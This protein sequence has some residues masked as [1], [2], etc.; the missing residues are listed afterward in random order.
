MKVLL[1][2]AH[3]D[4]ESFSC[5]GTLIKLAQKGA[6]ISLITATYGQQGLTGPYKVK[7][8]DEVGEIRK[9]ELEQAAKIIGIQKIH[10]FGMMDG[11]LYKYR[12]TTLAKK[13]LPVM[14]DENPDIVITF[15]KK[16]GSNHPDHI[17]MSYAATHAF[18]EYMAASKKH[19]RLYH[20]VTPRSY[21]VRYEKLGLA[22]TGFGSPKGVLDSHIT[23]KVDISD[24]FD[25]KLKVLACHKTQEKDVERYLT[26]GKHVDLKVEFFKLIAENA[27][28]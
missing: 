4:D 2:Y 14:K 21:Y 6:Q 16:G 8:L 1:V 23:T 19:V 5:S 26:R 22:N 9:K 12:I 28:S 7:T 25:Q 18:R 13:V 10:Y 27:L 17:R 24:V 11:T 20:T 15:E 3:P